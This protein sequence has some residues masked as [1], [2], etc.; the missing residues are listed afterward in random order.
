MKKSQKQV[1]FITIIAIITTIIGL[2]IND[3]TLILIALAIPIPLFI[4][5]NITEK[6]LKN[7]PKY[8]CIKNIKKSII[9]FIFSYLI[10]RYL[11]GYI[12]MKNNYDLYINNLLYLLIPI[13]IIMGMLNYYF[14]NKYGIK[15]LIKNLKIEQNKINNSI[16]NINVFIIN[17]IS[18]IS[19]ILFMS[20]LIIPIGIGIEHFLFN[21]IYDNAINRNIFY[22]E[23]FSINIA[24]CISFYGWIFF[25]DLYIVKKTI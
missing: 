2:L 6:Y 18:P 13:I 8:V 3:T 22:L 19:L 14:F 25:Q 11:Y 20:W 17:F 21:N 1:I 7:I 10:I 16:T 4:I 5:I 9:I 12:L 15:D 24:F 23:I